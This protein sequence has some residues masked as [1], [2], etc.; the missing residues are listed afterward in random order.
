M[1]SPSVPARWARHLSVVRGAVTAPA[2][3]SRA[4][5]GYSLLRSMVASSL[6]SVYR[7][8]PAAAT[9]DGGGGS[10]DGGDLGEGLEVLLQPPQAEGEDEEDDAE[11]EG[12]GG[13]EP[14]HGQGAGTREEGKEEAE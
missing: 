12:V 6:G 5:R 8:A 7:R 13:D 9:S 4:L 2:K 3:V 14:Q 10:P 1:Y 11:D